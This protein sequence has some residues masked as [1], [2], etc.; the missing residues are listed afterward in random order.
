MAIIEPGKTYI[1]A[2]GRRAGQKAT[3]TKIVDDRFVMVKTE[4][5]KERKSAVSH[6]RVGT[7]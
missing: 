7:K 2:K 5:G 1:L 4:K 3:V 6:L